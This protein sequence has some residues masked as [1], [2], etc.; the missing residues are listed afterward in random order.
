MFSRFLFVFILSVLIFSSFAVGITGASVIVASDYNVKHTNIPASIVYQQGK[1]KAPFDS[2]FINSE[3]DSATVY[4]NTSWTSGIYTDDQGNTYWITTS[5]NVSVFNAFSNFSYYLPSIPSKYVFSPFTSVASVNYS[6]FNYL[7]FNYSSFE[8]TVLLNE[9]G[10]AYAYNGVN[11]SWFNATLTWGLNLQNYPG[12]WVSVT[13][14]VMRYDYVDKGESFFFVSYSGAVASYNVRSQKYVVFSSG[15]NLAI[16]SSVANYNETLSSSKQ[17]YGLEWNGSVYYFKNH[18]HYWGNV[19]GSPGSGA[20]SITIGYDPTYGTQ[21]LFVSLYQNSSYLYESNNQAGAPSSGGFFETGTPA[22]SSGTVESLTF[23]NY[24]YYYNFYTIFYEAETNGTIAYSY[25]LTTWYYIT[26]AIPATSYSDV[27]S[28][29]W[30][31]APNANPWTAY[32]EFQSYTTPW[33]SLAFNI[34]FSSNR[35][36]YEYNYSHDPNYLGSSLMQPVELSPSYTVKVSYTGYPNMM[37][38][39]TFSFAVTFT[40]PMNSSTAVAIVYNLTF[41]IINH[42]YYQPVA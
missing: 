6:S 15:Q 1:S 13:S 35:T 32:A 42:F 16:I 5:G 31:G 30:K 38:N 41:V 39:S 34:S 21:N 2:A 18:W 9:K 26:N 22:F 4:L 7:S 33:D 19:F 36:G 3:G 37:G 29:Q 8:F 23:D 25:D 24:D 12:P 10:F 14:N 17:L 40:Y 20:V 28:I 11:S 27:V